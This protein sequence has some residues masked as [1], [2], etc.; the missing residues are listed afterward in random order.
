V[1][2]TDTRYG[3][4]YILA[5]KSPNYL[6]R[7]EMGVVAR[8]PHGHCGPHGQEPEPGHGDDDVRSETQDII[9]FMF[10]YKLIHFL[11]TAPF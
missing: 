10:L 11:V 9:C 7:S 6:D 1:L 2:G 4:R 5:L 3:W 8:G